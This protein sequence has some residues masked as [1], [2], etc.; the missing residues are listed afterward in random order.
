[1]HMS[2]RLSQGTF[3][4]P[5]KLDGKDFCN[6]STKGTVWTRNS[7]EGTFMG[8]FGMLVSILLRLKYVRSKWCYRWWRWSPVWHLDFLFP[9]FL[10]LTVADFLAC[11]FSFKCTISL[12]CIWIV[13]MLNYNSHCGDVLFP[14]FGIIDCELVYLVELD[15]ILFY[16]L[17]RD[18]KSFEIKTGL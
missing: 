15:V 5:A 11:T 13:G 18:K 17:S 1:M 16:I 8:Y 3:D 6:K 12:T 14:L 7:W 10:C 2:Y 4:S 9:S